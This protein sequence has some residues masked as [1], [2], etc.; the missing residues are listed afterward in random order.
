MKQIIDM[1]SRNRNL[2]AFAFPTF[3]VTL[4]AACYG[5][6]S[7]IYAKHFGL[8]LSSIATV[9]LV[10]RIFDAINDPLVGLYSDR[11]RLSTGSR[12]SFFM[13]GV[14]MVLVCSYFLFVPPEDV[15]L[16]YFIFWFFGFLFSL[17]VF[18]IP[19]VAWANEVAAETNE[20]TLVF[21][22]MAV[23]QKAGGFLFYLV[24][25]LPF[26]S[27]KEVTPQVVEMAVIIG[28]A[29]TIP[30]AL[31][32]VKF[33]PDGKKRSVPPKIVTIPLKVRLKGVL[34]PFIRN[35]PLLIYLVAYGGYALGS[36]LWGGLWFI[37]VDAYR[38]Q[39]E[40]YVEVELLSSLVGFA[41]MPLVYK[42]S[43]LCGKKHT[44]LMAMMLLIA[45]YSV[46]GFSS[47]DG[48][49]WELFFLRSL[50]QVGGGGLIVMASIYGDIVDYGTLMDREER[51]GTY[52]A[53]KTFMVKSF[54]ALGTAIGLSVVAWGGFDATAVSH[55]DADAIGFQVAMTVLP[56]I[57]TLISML[58]IVLIPIDERR[59]NIIRRRLDSRAQRIKR[60]EASNRSATTMPRA[61][62]AVTAK[63]H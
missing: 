9:I 32:M 30:G 37:Y 11:I 16:V 40:L 28:I 62:K 39:G 31:F 24:P 60:T 29:L 20:K 7:G 10:G 15:G 1:Y 48:G 19:K 42:V 35:K 58:F 21:T 6:M 34:Q 50:V 51:S 61:Y 14:V 59:H 12:K 5:V 36:G 41:A 57:F 45:G 4:I 56:V 13:A 38:G 25:F 63:N 17:T 43:L 3:G 47:R 53:V 44:A 55:T 33:V 23:A 52:F 27:S 2:L 18:S 22:A 8:A 26:F 54:I 46:T 49:F